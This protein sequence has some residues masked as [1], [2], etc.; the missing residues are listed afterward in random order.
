MNAVTRALAYAGH[1]HG[2]DALAAMWNRGPCDCGWE[3]AKAELQRELAQAKADDDPWSELR[4]EAEAERQ[5]RRR[6]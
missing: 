1:R 5:N 2:C 3:E 6:S 4:Q